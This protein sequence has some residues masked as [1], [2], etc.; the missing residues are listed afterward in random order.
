MTKRK[1][2]DVCC[3]EAKDLRGVGCQTMN[4][5]L[6]VISF[7]FSR[8]KYSFSPLFQ[9][10]SLNFQ[11]GLAFADGFRLC[12]PSS[13]EAGWLEKEEKEGKLV[14]NRGEGIW[15]VTC[16]ATVLLA[17]HWCLWRLFLKWKSERT[18]EVCSMK[19]WT[20][21]KESMKG[22]RD[23][24]TPPKL[25][26]PR[27]LTIGERTTQKCYTVAKICTRPF[28]SNSLKNDVHFNMC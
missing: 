12:V 3:G 15:A 5:P 26:L 24:E 19:K 13:Y 10:G 20:S 23:E 1:Q 25:F 6:L 7:L 17:S 14:W 8:L 28:T 11:V 27:Y 16:T 9:I 21:D 2:C 4:W 18:N 22:N